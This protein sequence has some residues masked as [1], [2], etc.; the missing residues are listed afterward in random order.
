M[1]KSMILT[2]A[3]GL[4]AGGASITTTGCGKKATPAAAVPGEKF[5]VT[6]GKVEMLRR[7]TPTVREANEMRYTLRLNNDLAGG[8][9]TVD[10][11]DFSYG[12]GDRDL[13]SSSLSPGTS[14]ASGAI[15]K[16]TLIGNFEWREDSAAPTGDGWVKGTVY[17][18][19]PNASRTTTF[20]L[21]KEYSVGE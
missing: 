1:N 16:V 4:L 5:A 12:V 6:I 10:K 17:W 13:G 2:L 15:A 14:V 3:L 7:G 20:D 18:T 8:A 21:S 9:V 11:I 19:G